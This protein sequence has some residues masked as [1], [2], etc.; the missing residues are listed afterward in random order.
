MGMRLYDSRWWVDRTVPAQARVTEEFHEAQ[1]KRC[2]RCGGKLLE[3]V[4]DH[5]DWNGFQISMMKCVDCGM[6]QDKLPAI[7]ATN[8]IVP[9]PR[10]CFKLTSLGEF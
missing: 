10:A 7:Y 5:P 1:N 6:F 9:N 2:Y 4:V 3:Y 8:V